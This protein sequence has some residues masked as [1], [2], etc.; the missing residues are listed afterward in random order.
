[1][2]SNPPSKGGSCS[3]DFQYEVPASSD[4]DGDTPRLL[5]ERFNGR[6]ICSAA[7]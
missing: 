5:R 4:V 1:M 7:I 3:D 6:N 2:Q